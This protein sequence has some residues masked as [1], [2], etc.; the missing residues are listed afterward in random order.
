MLNSRQDAINPC[1]W[2]R[3]TGIGMLQLSLSKPLSDGRDTDVPS[4]N[5]ALDES[6][7][8]HHLGDLIS[9]REIVDTT[10]STNADLLERARQRVPAR[11][12]LR[13]ARR[14]TQGRGRRGRRWHGNDAGS[15]LFS[16]ALPWGRDPAASAAVTL[17]CG[18]AAAAAVQECLPA[19]S[20]RVLVKWPNDLL[21]NGGKLAGILVEL[22]DDPQ[23]A[24]TLVIGMG[25]NLYCDA[26][27]RARVVGDSATGDPAPAP[28]AV[29][30]LASLLGR[31][32]VL[33]QREIWLARL[34]RAL[35]AAAQRYERNG[36][37]G[38]PAAFAACCAYRDVAVEAHGSGGPVTTG[39]VRG[40]DADGRLLLERGGVLCPISSGEISVRRQVDGGAP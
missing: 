1:P 27:L 31:T 21:V 25:I 14:Q 4:A 23:G 37:T 34:A 3:H 19:R 38:G 32:T 8:A 7:L 39:I 30:D 22:A 20:A 17:A 11:P 12:L 36:F 33:G 35:L 10:A 18:I 40:V 29:A 16:L 28:V 13:V 24:R 6:I 5:A 2:L 26:A 15:L 9:D